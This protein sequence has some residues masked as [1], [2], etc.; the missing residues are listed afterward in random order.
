MAADTLK[1]LSITNLDATA[2]GPLR[3]VAGEGAPGEVKVLNDFLTPTTGG[4]V[5]TSS[6]YKIVRIPSNAKIKKV[7]IEADAALDTNGSPT[8][9]VNLGLYYS[10]STFDGTQ[11]ANQGTAL[12]HTC[13]LSATLFGAATT[14]SNDVNLTQ[15][16]RN[17]P[18]WQG[19]GQL[20]SDPG[21]YLDVV[22]EVQTVAA[23]AQASNFGV[24]VE[25]VF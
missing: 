2:P 15:Q 6:V 7:K 13:F 1:T 20:A 18:A 25:Y 10:D 11:V 3:N 4:L 16:Y 17:Q 19:F 23:T 14:L 22:V 5:S 8:L 21:G 24:S 12:A 9:K